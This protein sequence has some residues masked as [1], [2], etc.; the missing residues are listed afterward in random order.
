MRYHALEVP[1]SRDL[2]PLPVACNK[3]QS[4]MKC[5]YVCIGQQFHL[6]QE[7]H[8][9][10]ENIT[11]VFELRPIG[12]IRDPQLPLSSFFVP[13]S[14]IHLMLKVN[15]PCQIELLDGIL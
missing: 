7:S 5:M 8:G 2:R 11:F 1:Q 3:Q 15:M 4:A 12:Q 10:H 6:L 13:L 9:V 14:V